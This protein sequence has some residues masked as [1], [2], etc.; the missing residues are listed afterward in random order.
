MATLLVDGGGLAVPTSRVPSLV[1]WLATYTR[2]SE[3]VQCQAGE[4]NPDPILRA[5]CHQSLDGTPVKP[6]KISP[7]ARPC[8]AAIEAHVLRHIDGL[9]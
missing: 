1:L 4:E 8:C 5:L 9:T 3:A 7:A 6:F 2:G